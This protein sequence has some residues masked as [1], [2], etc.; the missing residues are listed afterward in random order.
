MLDSDEKIPENFIEDS[1]KY[2][3]Y[4]EKLGALQCVH[5]AQKP[6]NLF[7]FFGEVFVKTDSFIALPSKLE[8]GFSALIGHGMMIS[9][10]AIADVGF[11]PECIVED[12]ALSLKLFERGYQIDYSPLIVCEEEFP[13]NYIIAKKR[14]L[15]W[16]EGDVEVQRNMKDC[17]KSKN[18]PAF[19]RFDFQI[20]QIGN[21][22]IPFI[23]FLFTI[24]NLVLAIL[25]TNIFSVMPYLGILFAFNT[26]FPFV[27]DL[28]LFL[29]TKEC[30]K[31]PIYWIS[32]TLVFASYLPYMMLRVTRAWFGKKPVFNVTQKGKQRVF[33]VALLREM[34]IPVIFIGLIALL[35]YFAF[36]TITPSIT[37]VATGIAL[38]FIIL[39]ANIELKQKSKKVKMCSDNIIVFEPK[40]DTSAEKISENLK[41]SDGNL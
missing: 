2:F 24:S 27:K 10:R 9:K 21:Y 22:K 35:T 17:Y 38:P 8:F 19:L 11:F 18:L 13:P 7:Q 41:I 1:L 3:F 37:F 14:R 28:P 4:N 34:I 23:I 12:Y 26:I 31:L 36:S 30:W 20:A 39:C 6:R 15:R 33:W 29:F 32:F 5:T 40:K 25:G 16:H